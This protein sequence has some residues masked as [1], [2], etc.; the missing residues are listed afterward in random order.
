[1]PYRDQAEAALADW[2]AADRRMAGLTPGSAAWQEAS[3]AAA[4]ARR[5]YQST[6]DEARAVNAPEP[7]PFDEALADSEPDIDVMTPDPVDGQVY[8]G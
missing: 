1:V 2:R 7:P 5:R 4:L 8:G 6:V 3:D